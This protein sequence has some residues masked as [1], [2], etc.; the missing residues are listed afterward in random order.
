MSKKVIK[1]AVIAA[2]VGAGILTMAACNKDNE[3]ADGDQKSQNARTTKS[4]VMSGDVETDYAN[5]L[6]YYWAACDSA[7][8]VNPG[9]FMLV[10]GSENLNTL[11]AMTGLP[12]N[13]ESQIDSLGRLRGQIYFA[14]HPDELEQVTEPC[15]DCMNHSMVQL[16]EWI[17]DIRELKN[18]IYAVSP[19]EDQSFVFPLR[20]STLTE[21]EKECYKK[22]LRE[23]SNG[24]FVYAPWC[25]MFCKFQEYFMYGTGVYEDITTA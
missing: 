14:D 19:A 13:I 7:Y 6:H 3:K 21:C 25:F 9:L 2:V 18:D 12:A 11:H 20:C 1:A 23:S 4:V 16:G 24:L 17:R 22:I 5:L 15:Q 10:C 8:R